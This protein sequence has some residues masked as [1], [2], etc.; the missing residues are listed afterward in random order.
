MKCYCYLSLKQCEDAIPETI[1][2]KK[3]QTQ[4]NT[5]NQKQKTK[6]QSMCFTKHEIKQT[7][8]TGGQKK[9]KFLLYVV[10]YVETA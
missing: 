3:N 5:K 7:N 8:E 9:L 2:K 10:L 4:T 6:T 1:F